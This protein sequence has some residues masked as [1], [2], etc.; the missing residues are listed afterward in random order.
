VPREKTK[1]PTTPRADYA[2]RFQPG[3]EIGVE[4]RFRPK[5]SGNPEGT[6]RARRLVTTEL[7]R[8]ID[9][10]IVGPAIAKVWLRQILEA[11]WPFFKLFIDRCEDPVE[12][13]D[14]IR[15]DIVAAPLGSPENPI[16]VTPTD[17]DERYDWYGTTCPCGLEA[18]TCRK[19]PRAREQQ[20][21]PYGPWTTWA[22]IAGRGSGKTRSAAEWIQDR[23]DSGVMRS[24]MLIA[25]IAS[26]IRDIMIEGESG[27]LAIAPP[28]NRPIYQ[29]SKRRVTWPNGAKA[30]CLTGEEPERARGH[31]VDT[32]WADELASWQRPQ[33]TWDL[34]MLCLRAGKDPRAMISTTPKRVA[35]LKSIIAE[36][37]T[38]MTTEDTFANT[39]NLADVF[40]KKITSRYDGTR[41]GRQ[42]IYAEFLETTEGVWFAN[43]NPKKHVVK[44]AEYDDRYPVR[45]AID[46][47]TSRHTAAVWFQVRPNDREGWPRVTV[48][49]EYHAVDVVSRTNA[50]AIK[51]KGLTLPC[52]GRIDVVR[53]DPAATAKSS[54]GPAA[55]GEYEKVFGMRTLSRWPMHLV[56]D[57]LDTIELLL[58]SG[59]LLIHPRCVKL[60]ESF[61]NYCRKKRGGEFIDFPADGHPEEDMMDA[62]RGGIRDAMPE[63]RK[64]ESTLIPRHVS[65]L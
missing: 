41:L 25:A 2:N 27:L 13:L 45:I 56:L 58:D 21:P 23:V 57:G 36:D 62:L 24:G 33:E 65:Q 38:V 20:R 63:G 17:D 37:T 14:A 10:K 39:A 8:L 12:I 46:A 1:E 30:I 40:I 55:Y 34:A 44:E 31:N 22:Y 42:E 5:T 26:D 49:G 52:D 11:N 29:V 64:G 7:E 60:K 35:I 48:F 50:I 18:G 19:H 61:N 54:L 51:A 15:D 43:F 9:A 59:N 32:I 53:M 47:G 3:N 4:T 16:D 6:T 28:G